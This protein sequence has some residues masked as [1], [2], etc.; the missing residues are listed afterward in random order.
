MTPRERAAALFNGPCDCAAVDI[1]V[2]QM[3]EPLC[4]WPREDDI[5]T[6]ILEAVLEE[7]NRCLDGTAAE[8]RDCGCATRIANRIRE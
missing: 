8:A 4:R 7:R 3:H 6:A 2:G 1:G 5:C